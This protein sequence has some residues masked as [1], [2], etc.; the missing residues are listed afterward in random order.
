[1]CKEVYSF[2]FKSTYKQY[3]FI[4]NRNVENIPMD[5]YTIQFNSSRLG[6]TATA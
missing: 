3:E 5:E 4:K 2:Q 6:I 1:M